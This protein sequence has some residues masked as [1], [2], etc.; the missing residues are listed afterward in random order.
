M[1]KL[2]FDLEESMKKCPPQYLYAKGPNDEKWEGEP[3]TKF[4]KRHIMRIDNVMYL[5]DN[6]SKVEENVKSNIKNISDSFKAKGWDHLEQ[7]LV[8]WESPDGNKGDEGFHRKEAAGRNNWET[9]P[10]D[11]VEYDSPLDQEVSKHN[12]NNGLPKKINRMKDTVRAVKRCVD[13]GRI[14]ADKTKDPNSVQLINL[15]KRLT[16]GKGDDHRKRILKKY[17]ALDSGYSTLRTYD[18]N[19]AN[20]L[21]EKLNLPFS[22]VKNFEMTGKVGYIKSQ[23]SFKSLM[24]DCMTLIVKDKVPVD[25][26]GNYIPIEIRAFIEEPSPIPAVLRTQ[27]VNWLKSFKSDCLDFIKTFYTKTTGIDYEYI[28]PILFKGFACQD[29]TPNEDNKGLPME[30]NVVLEDWMINLLS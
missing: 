17:R 1:T 13:K 26:D 10:F 24:H 7:P 9:L 21:C 15:I 11:K 28:L 18:G 20:E 2:L 6:Q 3:G 12:S 23:G 4:L 16:P 30:D 8:Y 19:T 29:I 22:G 14:T 27:R 5:I 25:D